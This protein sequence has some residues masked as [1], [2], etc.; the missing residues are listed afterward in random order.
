LTYEYPGWVMTYET[1]NTNGFGSMGRL[2]PGRLHHGALG[3]ENRPNGMAFFGS[4]GT[5]IVDRRGL[6]VIPAEIPDE[7]ILGASNVKPKGPKLERVAEDEDEPTVLHA[8]HFV[9]CVRDGE[10]PRCDATVGH[11][12]TN[13]AHL[14]NISYRAGR[15]IAWDPDKEEIVGDEEASA[16]MGRKA[17]APWNMI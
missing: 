10:K 8:R 17:R 15:R 5:M 14:G 2:T 13:V 9:R 16:L 1:L 7:R 6:E 4:N 11:R 12:A 3:K